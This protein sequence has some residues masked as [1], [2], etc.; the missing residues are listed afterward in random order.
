M[1]VRLLAGGAIL[2][3][4]TL[5]VAWLIPPSVSPAAD[6]S[7]NTSI[8]WYGTWQGGLAAAKK[9]GRPILLISAAPHCHGTPGIW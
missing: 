4:A 7:E 8:A 2:T 1:R 5:S 9:T 6:S 3:A